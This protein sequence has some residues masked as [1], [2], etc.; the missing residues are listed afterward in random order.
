MLT[1]VSARSES[2]D[3]HRP[4][5]LEQSTVSNHSASNAPPRTPPPRS[6][7]RAAIIGQRTQRGAY[8]EA[9]RAYSLPLPKEALIYGAT[10][11]L[12]LPSR[13]ALAWDASGIPGSTERSDGGRGVSPRV[14][15]SGAIPRRA[16]PLPP[17]RGP[18]SPEEKV[19]SHPLNSKW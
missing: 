7:A 3:A 14:M 6:P 18:P 11:S 5:R 2:A 9:R 1:R 8:S 13:G 10:H 16:T 12:N 4:L 17:L 15:I 19:C